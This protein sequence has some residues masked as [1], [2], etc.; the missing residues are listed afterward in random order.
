MLT[1]IPRTD[2]FAR[3]RDGSSIPPWMSWAVL[4]TTKIPDIWSDACPGAILH[5]CHDL[6]EDAVPGRHKLTVCAQRACL[7][8]GHCSACW[9]S[10]DGDNPEVRRQRLAWL[11]VGLMA[12]SSGWRDDGVLIVPSLLSFSSPQPPRK[13]ASQTQGV[14]THNDHLFVQGRTHRRHGRVYHLW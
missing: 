7:T 8:T 6:T 13:S 1:V 2:S 11:S 9:E 3:S 5:A 12:T 14:T 4:N 10:L